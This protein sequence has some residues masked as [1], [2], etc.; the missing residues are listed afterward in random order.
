MSRHVLPPHCD[1]PG[2][3]VGVLY[4]K[5]TVCGFMVYA[6]GECPA[7]EDDEPIVYA[8]DPE[9]PDF[10]RQVSGPRIVLAPAEPVGFYLSEEL[11]AQ[12][13]AALDRERVRVAFAWL[14]RLVSFAALAS[15]PYFS[16]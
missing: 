8:P 9:H 15:E 16:E 6:A 13:R 10:M 11:V 12:G 2:C 5:C 14:A 7:T 1:D 3:C 4:A